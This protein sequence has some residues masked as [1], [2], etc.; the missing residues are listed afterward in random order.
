MSDIYPEDGTQAP[1]M[2]PEPDMQSA[3]LKDQ[4]L[5]ARDRLGDVKRTVREEAATF[6]SS[7]KEKAIGQ[8]EQKQA[9]VTGAIGDF[10]DAVRKA[11]DELTDRNQ[12]LAAQVVRHAADGLEGVSRSL[13]G[14]RPADLLYAVRDFGRRNPVAFIGGTLLIGLAVGRFMRSSVH[15]PDFDETQTF[16]DD[17]GAEWG[18]E[19]RS[20]DANSQTFDA[21]AADLT[22]SPDGAGVSVP[23]DEFGSTPR[24]M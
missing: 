9:A 10:A 23:D 20:L 7:A 16:A 15:E 21:D 13:E 1:G 18:G 24:G 14:K 2:R 6:A 4:A 12:T 5:A 3:S 19:A 17:T 22:M 8:V 11:G